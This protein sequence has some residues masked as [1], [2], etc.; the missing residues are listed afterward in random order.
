[1]MP[2]IRERIRGSVL[3]Q[4]FG[5]AL[6]APF[7]FAP[8]D[9]VNWIE[10]L[11]AF[12]GTTSPH[13]LWVSPAPKGT[14]TDDVR[15]NR[16]FIDLVVEL[17][18]RMPDDAE[19]AARLLDV[20]ENPGKYFPGFEEFA[21]GQFGMWEG[22][23]RGCLGQ[24]SAAHPGVPPKILATRSV[25][26]NY[27]TIAGL[28]IMPSAGLLYPDDPEKAYQAAYE[29]AFFD[30]AYAREA[31]ALFAAAQSLALAGV[32]P[33]DVVRSVLTM[34]PL[35]LGGYFGGPFVTEN[36][37]TLLDR[38][39]GLRGPELSTWLSSELRQFSVFDPYRAL[40]IVFAALLA[41]SEEPMMVLQVAANHMDMDAAGAV[42]RYADIDCY[43]GFAGALVGTLFGDQVLRPEA[44]AQVLESNRTV[45]GI[46]LEQ[47]ASRLVDVVAPDGGEHET[48][49]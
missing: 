32:A 17:G 11:C 41:H 46:D 6:G 47:V 10:E 14:G 43:A 18:G 38:A 30:V 16:L 49:Q 2:Q 42:R 4:A 24:N 36:L 15:Y 48:D 45:Y 34:D 31:T 19:L 27:P 1:M 29:A 20:H 12:T 25:G 44:R 26:L 21:R 13:G 33:A 23:C 7:E 9:A 8:P 5:D 22:V 3:G 39:H 40:A 37:P 28:L 35:H